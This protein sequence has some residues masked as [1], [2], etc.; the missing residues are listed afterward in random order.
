MKKIMNSLYH[1]I[2]SQKRSFHN[3]MIL[4]PKNTTFLK[5]I[6]MIFWGINT[7]LISD[8]IMPNVLSD[9]LKIRF[10]IPIIVLMISIIAWCIFRIFTKMTEN[11]IETSIKYKLLI[12]LLFIPL[13]MFINQLIV[14]LKLII[15]QLKNIIE[16]NGRENKIS[17]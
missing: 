4:E 12:S 2:N 14:W 16:Q 5:A 13:L 1:W 17:N 10:V 7:M 11:K 6:N 15:K 9:R 8:L 3:W